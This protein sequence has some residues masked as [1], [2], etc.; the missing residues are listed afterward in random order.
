MFERYTEKARRVI[1]FARYEA[2]VFWQSDYRVL[3]FLLLGLLRE[4]KNVVTRWLGA[5]DWQKFCAKRSEGTSMRDGRFQ[6]LLI[7]PLSE[8]AKR[9]PVVRGG[10]GRAALPPN[11]RH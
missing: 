1:F 5:G 2:S 7:F 10:G 4:S 6:H 3:S 11:D 8:E 9:V